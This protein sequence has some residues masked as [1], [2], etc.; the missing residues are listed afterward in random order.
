MIRYKNEIRKEDKEA[1]HH[2]MRRQYHYL[3]TPEIH[4]ELESSR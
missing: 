2:L 3:V 4:R 1:L